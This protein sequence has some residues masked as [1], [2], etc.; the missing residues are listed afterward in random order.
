MLPVLNLGPLSLPL[1]ELLLILGFWGGSTIMEKNNPSRYQKTEFLEKLL[2]IS[3]LA[4]L[5]GARLSFFARYPE[6]FKGNYLSLLSINLNLFDLSGGLIIAAGTGLFLIIN[7]KK[8]L[9]ST[10]DGLTSFFSFFAMTIHLSRF[11]SGAGYGT[12]T[13]I[14][15][16]I[17]LWG[18]QRH[19][20]RI[21]DLIGGLLVFLI[22]NLY[23]PRYHY[24]KG[25]YLASFL[26]FTSIYLLIF[27]R[28]QSPGIV[29]FEGIRLNQI[30]YLF[31][32][33]ISLYFLLRL[34]NPSNTQDPYASEK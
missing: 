4:G 21:Y 23:V 27:S 26:F 7:N 12:E 1:P 8:D 25:F 6:T 17:Q 22:I 34:T 10:L 30:I 11:S 5:I 2:W 31:S 33:I 15:W 20:V 16:G 28:Y 29:I 9:L 24:T 18:A 3:L 14:P 19:P 13:N 32:S